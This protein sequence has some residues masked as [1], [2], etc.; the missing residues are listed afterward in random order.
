MRFILFSVYAIAVSAIMAA[1]P[2]AVS[3]QELVA[4][5]EAQVREHV[6]G[7]TRFSTTDLGNPYAMYYDPDG[8]YQGKTDFGAGSTAF[9][10]TWAI[11]GNQLCITRGSGQKAGTQTCI[12]YVT[13]GKQVQVVN[14][15]GRTLRREAGNKVP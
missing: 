6:A 7:R 5:T 15:S 13:D 1:T 9:N 10:G 12:T 8:T 11:V 2:F 3:A 14:G 4:A